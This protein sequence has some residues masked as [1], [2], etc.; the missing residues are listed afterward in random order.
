MNIDF[1]NNYWNWNEIKPVINVPSAWYGHVVFGRFIVSLMKPTSIV[2]LGVDKG[3]S[4]CAF[5]EE[6]KRNN[7]PCKVYGIDSWSEGNLE[8]S[9]IKDFANLLPIQL[10]RYGNFSYLLPS[11]FEFAKELFQDKS[12]DLLHIDGNHYYEY[13]CADYNNYKDKLSDKS[14]IL[15]HDVN[16]PDFGTFQFWNEIKS[17]RPSFMFTHS[18]GLGV[19]LYGNNVNIDVVDFINFANSN[20]Q[21]VQNFFE[22]KSRF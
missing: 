5:C 3:L 13:I 15:F 1:L 7:I 18:Y 9:S 14:V 10:E 21:V 4:F 12:I 17:S 2:E 19:L 6:V 20:P 16:W 8:I 11:K 22:S